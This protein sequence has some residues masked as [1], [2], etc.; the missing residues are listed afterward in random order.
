M[1]KKAVRL[2][3]IIN[4]GTLLVAVV[5]AA[6][7]LLSRRLGLGLFDCRFYAMFGVCCPGC[8]G[9]RAVLALLALDP[10]RAVLY[11]PP[12]PLTVLLLLDYDVRLLIDAVRNS[13][14]A[15]R[16]FRSAAW[17]AIPA[18]IVLTFAVRLILTLAFS[19]DPLAFI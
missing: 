8:G 2:L 10:V 18:A 1:R 6:L 5:Y 13:D 12:I 16:G 7:F 19:I 3:L 15:Q 17:L 14:R 9:S 11:Y 4:L